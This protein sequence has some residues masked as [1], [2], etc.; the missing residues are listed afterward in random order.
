[1]PGKRLNP[2]LAKVHRTYTIEEVARLFV[3]HRQ[4]VRN[5]IKSGLP[6]FDKQRP[7]LI[8]G[9]C[10]RAFLQVR[11]NQKKRPCKPGELYCMRC[12]QPRRPAAGMLEYL[13]ITP[14]SGNLRA[15]CPSCAA[16][17]HR[18]V[19]LKKIRSAVGQNPV[20]FPDGQ[21]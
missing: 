13:A 12:R 21:K 16:L 3:V 20:T 10:L 18:R 8:S 4:T 7:I 9:D 5:W 14:S 17:M 11:R 19:N 2:N 1:M 6:K 15:L